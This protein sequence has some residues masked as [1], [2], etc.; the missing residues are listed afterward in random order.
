MADVS[1]K[2]GQS[3]NLNETTVPIVEG[4]IIVTEDKG[5]MFVD[6][7]SGTRKKITD[8]NK[9]DK[10]VSGTNIKTINN[11][12]ILGS[13][14]IIIEGGEGGGTAITIDQN[15]NSESENAQSGKAVAEAMAPIEEAIKNK[16][17][18]KTSEQGEVF[19]NYASNVASAKYTHAEGN[20]TEAIAEASHAEG[21]KVK[22][23]GPAAHAEGVLT[24][25]KGT[26]SHTEGRE[27]VALGYVAHAEGHKTEAI[28]HGSHTEGAITKA[29]SDNAH[30]E[31]VST[32]AGT[33]GFKITDIEIDE[34]TNTGTLFVIDGSNAVTPEQTD[35]VY[36]K[37]TDYVTDKVT[38]CYAVGDLLNIDVDRH[39]YGKY[40]ITSLEDG[41]IHFTGIDSFNVTNASDELV[42]GSATE[43][44]YVWVENKP[45]GGP[46]EQFSGIHAEGS[47]T[48]AIGW[49][50]HSE[51]RNT[52]AIGNYSHAEGRQTTANYGAHAEGR[53]TTAKGHMSHAEGQNTTTIG[54]CA[55]AEGKNTIAKGYYA[56]AEGYATQANGNS[57]HASGDHTVAGY[58]NQFVT[59]KYNDNKTN[60]LFE[61][62]YGLADNQRKNAFEVL[63]TGSAKVAIQGSDPT[64]VVI[65]STLTA[66]LNKKPGVK[67]SGGEK[68]NTASDASGSA[69]H[70]E[71][72][73]TI[74]SG[75][76][77]HAEGDRTK[78]YGHCS[79]AE[80]RLTEAGVTGASAGT[81]A[82]AE[83]HNTKATAYCAHSEGIDTL[84]QHQYSH[85]G[86][87]GTKT[88][89]DCQTVI[90]KYNEENT[91]ALFQVG[92]GSSDSA[93]SNAF[94]VCADNNSNAWAKVKDA[95]VCTSNSNINF[96][97]SETRP[98]NAPAGT[99]WIQLL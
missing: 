98:E 38:E 85:A 40:S 59:G 89:R 76:M 49:G 30:A 71:G 25:A 33:K 19:N 73:A 36:D 18:I 4:Q 31:G 99:I 9:Q 82:H 10:L 46:I 63:D 68:F 66:E 93:R 79:H 7:S 47:Y 16:P 24:E 96:V 52:K 84:A 17:G 75:N 44:N 61:V 57:S 50:A 43:D 22:V 83:G 42:L 51:G 48:T 78:A 70:A 88:S 6:M 95:F 81:A 64:S 55:H 5:E 8:V 2:R 34:T 39:Q 90:G 13:G 12:S 80:G 65:N 21:Y 86:G 11:Q 20:T 58:T 56:H 14:N 53:G 26:S 3:T 69:S 72:Y 92:C 67:V 41:K 35:D 94:E 27:T 60:S 23:S 29:I 45:F 28:G 74:S 91:E 1:Y 97:V 15:Y 32:T 87:Q 54:E 37:P 77:S 62:G